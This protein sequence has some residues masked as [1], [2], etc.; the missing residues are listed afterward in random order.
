[1]LKW[2]CN[3]RNLKYSRR[4]APVMMSSEQHGSPPHRYWKL[5]FSPS[6][7]DPLPIIGCNCLL[8]PLTSPSYCIVESDYKLY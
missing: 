3:G 5:G 8:L 1:M 2:I 6:S 4:R 7:I